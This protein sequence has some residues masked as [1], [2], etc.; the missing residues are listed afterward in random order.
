MGQL[1]GEVEA[2][3]LKFGKCTISTNFSYFFLYYVL[4]FAASIPI[5]P[6]FKWV[7]LALI[8]DPA[9]NS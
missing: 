7:C 3:V 2:A 1:K 5:F 6:I 9:I 8:H 4:Y